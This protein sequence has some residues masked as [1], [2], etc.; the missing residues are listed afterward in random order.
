MKKLLLLIMLTVFAVAVNKAQNVKVLFSNTHFEIGQEDQN[1]LK[2]DFTDSDFIYGLVIID[3]VFEPT[4]RCSGDK[5][6]EANNIKIQY[7]NSLNKVYYSRI[8]V[9]NGKTYIFLDILPEVKYASSRDVKSWR[10]YLNKTPIGQKLTFKILELNGHNCAPFES[11]KVKKAT[12]SYI[13]NSN[14]SDDNLRTHS[15]MI[16]DEVDK[17]KDMIDEEDRQA[18]FR[19]KDEQDKKTGKMPI[20]YYQSEKW[21][22]KVLFSTVTNNQLI[23]MIKMKGDILEEG[24]EV[25]NLGNEFA[26]S[27][28]H[29]NGR[30]VNYTTHNFDIIGKDK[31]GN[32]W[33]Q[34]MEAYE[35]MINGS[36]AEPS[37]KAKSSKRYF[38]CENIVK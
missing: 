19:A 36:Y 32:C 31:D 6:Q 14:E 30:D 18:G 23:E 9:E 4:E 34:K 26:Q 8:I 21:K 28:Y 22:T 7:G 2:T 25:I 27:T 35:H 24:D 33:Y 16:Y 13:R 20:Q 29:P 10:D 1:E 12:F 37:L 17:L 38:N 5:W 3:E 15:R 11:L